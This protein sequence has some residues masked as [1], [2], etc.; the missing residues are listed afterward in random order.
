MGDVVGDYDKVV[1]LDNNITQD[2]TIHEKLKWLADWGG[3]VNFSQGLDARVIERKP[4]LAGLLADVRFSSRTFNGRIFTMAY[5]HP[6]Y[7]KIIGRTCGYLEDAGISLR[8]NVQFFV[9]CNYNTTFEEDLARVEHLRELGANPYVMV[10]DPKRAPLKIKRLQRWANR[11][12]L[13]WVTDWA[14]YSRNQF[15]QDL[16]E[17]QIGD[18]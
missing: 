10:F 9:L 15:D 8:N 18:F 14:G 2:P 16:G 17:I 12:Q 6:A 5:D 7:R 4:E 3:R 13:F 1:L 11:K